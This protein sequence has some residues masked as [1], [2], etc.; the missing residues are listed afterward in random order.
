MNRNLPFILANLSIIF[1]GVLY[2]TA[3]EHIEQEIRSIGLIAI[4]IGLFL[5]ILLPFLRNKYMRVVGIVAYFLLGIVQILPIDF[6]L[7]GFYV[8]DL[9]SAGVMDRLYF[10]PHLIVLCLSF[11]CVYSLLKYNKLDKSLDN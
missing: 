11:W 9:V 2:N 4:A 3:F 6:W 1:T 5:F 10:L 7:S 8:V